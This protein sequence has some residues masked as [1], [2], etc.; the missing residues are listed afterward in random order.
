MGVMLVWGLLPGLLTTAS[1][2]SLVL[3]DLESTQVAC[4]SP[5]SESDNR[6]STR[7]LKHADVDVPAQGGRRRVVS[8]LFRAAW[9][10]VAGPLA[11]ARAI[12]TPGLPRRI[13]GEPPGVR[14][15]AIAASM[16]ANPAVCRS[17]PAPSPPT[18]STASRCDG[19]TR[20][21]PREPGNRTAGA[22]AVLTRIS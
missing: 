15:V 21:R 13:G 16:P 19:E 2:N 18:R 14:L 3:E 11:L 10:A 8:S 5:E 7:L 1:K 20:R 6:S 12:P 9:K 4:C 17:V 22:P